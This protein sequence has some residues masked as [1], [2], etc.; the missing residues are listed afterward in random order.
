MIECRKLVPDYYE[1]SRDYQVFLKILDIIVNACKADID[2]FTSL[3][4]ADA[5]KSRMLPLLANYV[6]YNY[7]YEEKVRT[8]RVIIR[9]YPTLLRN[10]GSITGVRMAVAISMC[11]LDTDDDTSVYQLFNVSYDTSY[12]K[13]GREINVIRIYLFQEAY[14]SK[15]YDLI[16]AVRPAG[17]DVEII[18]S[19]PIQSA[20]T[21]VLTDEYR[22]I[23]YNYI[24]GKLI[25]ISDVNIIVQNSWEILDNGI[26]TNTFLVDDK[27]YDEFG[28]P[29]GYYIDSQQRIYDKDGKYTNEVIRAPYIY[30]ETSEGKLQKTTKQFDLNH[31]AKVLNTAYDIKSGGKSIGYFVSA[32]NWEIFNNT[33]TN[34]QFRLQDY[35]LNS[36]KTRKVYSKD[37]KTKFNWHVDLETG[38]FIKDSDGVSIDTT[39]Y[40]IP[41]DTNCYISKKRYIM[42]TSPT[43]VVYTTEYYVNK[44]EDIQDTAGNVILSQR[45]RYKVSDSAGVGFSEVCNESLKRTIDKTWIYARDY[46]YN[47]DRDFFKR[48]QFTEDYNEYSITSGSAANRIKISIRDLTIDPIY[49]EYDGTSNIGTIDKSS[50]NVNNNSVLIPIEKINDIEIEHSESY[51]H[52]NVA[53][54][55][56]DDVLSIFS[57]LRF[58]FEDA[59]AGSG[60]HVFL[61]WKLNTDAIQ[62]YD[63]SELPERLVFSNQGTVLPRKVTFTDDDIHVYDKVYDG[64]KKVYTDLRANDKRA[65]STIEV[66]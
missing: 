58:T 20:E 30:T 1:K 53:L 50:Q 59:D 35:T 24:T 27:F 11:Q 61:D 63:T 25:R 56:G 18:P 26:T 7:D 13:H 62:Y 31:S 37:G 44:F 12:D 51:F 47:S 17:V 32:D 43:G 52:I 64:T 16:E 48:K 40:V 46:S 19:I 41:W 33:K 42:N 66:I 45:D 2:F 5:C 65:D 23:A 55:K 28:N 4:S 60:K 10:R 57:Q 54:R 14:L 36:V 15:L 39:K 8:N 22:M 9:N 34:I 6:G 38:Y 49:R 21:I 29:T 3:L